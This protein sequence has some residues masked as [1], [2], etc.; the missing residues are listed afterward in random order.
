MSRDA[1]GAPDIIVARVFVAFV[2]SA[3]HSKHSPLKIKAIS[4]LS[5]NS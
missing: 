5:G 2:A 1:V 4:H 3:F